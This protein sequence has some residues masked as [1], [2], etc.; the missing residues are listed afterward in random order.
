VQNVLDRIGAQRYSGD[1]ERAGGQLKCGEEAGD[2]DERLRDP[3]N[4]PVQKFLRRSNPVYKLATW[5]A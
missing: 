4:L 2:E 3:A 1:A 5:S